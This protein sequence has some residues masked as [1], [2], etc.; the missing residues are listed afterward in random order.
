[1]LVIPGLHF[2]EKYLPHLLAAQAAPPEGARKTDR[3]AAPIQVKLLKRKKRAGAET[4]YYVQLTCRPTEVPV[5]TDPRLGAIGV[6]INAD[7]LA[8]TESDRYGNWI[9]SESL[10][11]QLKN[12]T[13]DQTEA[14]LGDYVAAIVAMAKEARKPLVIEELDFRKKKNTLREEGR[15]YARMLSSFAYSKFAAMIKSRAYSEGVQLIAVNP[16]FSSIIGAYKFYGL[17]ITTHEKAALALA[18]RALRFSERPKHLHNTRRPPAPSL[19]VERM[20][21]GAPKGIKPR[22]RQR[23]VWSIW[24]R[25]AKAIRQNFVRGR[26]QPKL[27]KAFATRNTKHPLVARVAARVMNLGNAGRDKNISQGSQASGDAARPTTQ[28]ISDHDQVWTSS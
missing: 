19:E 2:P 7:H 26:T 28:P 10:G 6:D 15:G 12:L 23:H 9:R 17:K 20:A 25:H 5:V 16:A 11:Y 3:T 27:S 14:V 4:A 1:M 13:S 18:R 22:T 21:G 8:V 24:G